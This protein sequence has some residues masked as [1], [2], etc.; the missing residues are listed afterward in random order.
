MVSILDILADGAR[1]RDRVVRDIHFTHETNARVRLCI[2]YEI[3]EHSHTSWP[4]CYTI[5]GA[6]RHHATS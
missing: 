4:A 1:T 6:D 5:V 3:L 2:L